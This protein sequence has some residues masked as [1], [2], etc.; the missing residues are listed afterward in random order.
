MD[1]HNRL[2]LRM[3]G[4]NKNTKLVKIFGKIATKNSIFQTKQT[5]SQG[6]TPKGGGAKQA[7]TQI[8][9]IMETT[10]IYMRDFSSNFDKRRPKRRINKSLFKEKLKVSMTKYWHN[11]LGKKELVKTEE[12]SVSKK[13]SLDLLEFYH[14]KEES[15][16]SSS[17]FENS[18]ESAEARTKKIHQF[19]D[20]NLTRQEEKKSKA[21][22]EK[23][24]KKLQLLNHQNLGRLFP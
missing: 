19:V 22:K 7:W 20:W 11:N 13:K 23:P 10:D 21:P 9:N 6:Q 12:N 16:A 24:K 17:D 1:L 4:E 18:V 15:S 8:R 14:K 2:N 3:F 5:N